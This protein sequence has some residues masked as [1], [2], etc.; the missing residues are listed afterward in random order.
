MWIFVGKSFISHH[1][2]FSAM[3]FIWRVQ[4]TTLPVHTLSFTWMWNS[5]IEFHFHLKFSGPNFTSC[6]I[7]YFFLSPQWGTFLLSFFSDRDE[8]E[9][10]VAPT[11][12]P[13]ALHRNDMILLPPFVN[14]VADHN[15]S[16]GFLYFVTQSF[17]FH[18]HNNNTGSLYPMNVTSAYHTQNTDSNHVRKRSTK[19]AKDQAQKHVV[20]SSQPMDRQARQWRAFRDVFSSC[21][22]TTTPSTQCPKLLLCRRTPT[23]PAIVSKAGF[24]RPVSNNLGEL[25]ATAR[26]REEPLP[27]PGST[28]SATLW[29]R[30][31]WVP[32]ERE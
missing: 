3:N 27:F 28:R 23:T 24:H 32:Y 4:F 15:Q 11:I 14:F 7:Q 31:E 19:E 9:H 25:G 30:I 18:H 1:V 21:G 20:D 22:S 5:I 17:L 16:I 6:E 8:F 26:A 29:K 10:N 2:K 12:P 13:Q